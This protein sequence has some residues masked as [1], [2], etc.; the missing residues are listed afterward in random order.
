[1]PR[2]ANVVSSLAL[3]L[4]LGGTAAAAAAL[5]RD[6]VGAPQIRADAVR[7]PELAPDAVRS[8]ELAADAVRSAEIRDKSIKI[9]DLA[10]GARSALDT[11][12]RVA[13]KAFVG[14]VPVC[15]GEDPTNC[16]VLLSRTLAP[17]SWLV[18]AKLVASAPDGTV[19]DLDNRCG[20]VA[21]D[22]APG[23]R[24]LDSA[25]IGNLKGFALSESMSLVGVVSGVEDRPAVTVRC[26]L[27][28][29]EEMDVEDIVI[30]ALEVGKITGLNLNTVGEAG[31]EITLP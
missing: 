14:D 9:G 2:Y 30:T 13:S 1:M 12:L 10:P 27:A 11:R 19:D 22:A 16:P 15:P 4:A 31:G 26:T 24:L 21:A 23:P 5:E 17:G 20:L 8:P 7:S 3:F 29:F 28:E 25:R 6:S 18:Q